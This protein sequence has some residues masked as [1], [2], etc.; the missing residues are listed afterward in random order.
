MTINFGA[1]LPYLPVMLKG[2]WISIE[3]TVLSFFIGS[4]AGVFVYLGRRSELAPLRWLAH[5][6]V[7]IFRNTPLLVQLY[8]IYFGLP[9]VGINLDP[10]WSTLLGMTL[11]NAAY[12]S[13]IFRAG[14][15]S[16]PAGLVEAAGALG[17]RSM[18]TFRFVV[19]KPAVRNVLPALTNQFIVLF[20]FSAVG[21]VISLNELTS[22]LAD[23]NQRTLRTL[24]IFTLG[25][26]LYY[27]TSAVIAGSSRLAERYLFRW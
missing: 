24:E 17:M 8:L 25:G 27:L 15:E 9:Q 16:V 4:V 26:L 19:L 5:A 21:S 3:V 20:L 12:T 22:A 2:L 10:F 13:E 14:I 18:Q 23:L 7:E 11:N 6:F 1:V